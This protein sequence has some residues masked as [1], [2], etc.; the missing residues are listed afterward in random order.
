MLVIYVDDSLAAGNYESMT[1]T[2]RI[3]EEWNSKPI[4][5]PSFM[6]ARVMVNQDSTE[7]LHEQITYSKTRQVTKKLW[8]DLFITTRRRLAWIIQRRPEMLSGVKI[9]SSQVTKEKFQDS[10]VKIK[11]GLMEQMKQNPNTG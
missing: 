9:L 5:F 6:F 10:N 3:P 8:L 7:V 11:N 2:N 4:D 1:F